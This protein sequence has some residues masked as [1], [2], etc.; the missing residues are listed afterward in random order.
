[1]PTFL[2][3]MTASAM[4]SS[5]SL[6]MPQKSVSLLVKGPTVT[7]RSL[8]SCFGVTVWCSM[9]MRDNYLW[10][11]ILGELQT[12]MNKRAPIVGSHHILMLC[13]VLHK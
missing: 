8:L 12:S 5:K 11:K 4:Y 1:M 3:V 10:K 6:A 2:R 13:A 9:V 7:K